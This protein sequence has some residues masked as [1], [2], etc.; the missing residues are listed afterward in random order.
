MY[1]YE[2]IIKLLDDKGYDYILLEHPPV[3]S[4]EDAEESVKGYEAVRTK[5]FFLT[6]KKNKKYYMIAM[7]VDTQVSMKEFDTILEEKNIHFSSPDKMYNKIGLKPGSVSVFGL[8]N[9]EEKDVEVIFDKALFA[10]EKCCFHVG[11]NTR[12]GIFYGEDIKNFVK[13]L[14]YDYKILDF[15]K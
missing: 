12:T 14:G 6:N 11:D 4:A 9:N 7:D 1:T 13:D 15:S 2:D 5:T 10:Q 3:E 8:L